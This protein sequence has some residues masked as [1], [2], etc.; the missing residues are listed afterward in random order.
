MAEKYLIIVGSIL[1]AVLG[2]IH[3]AYTFFSNKL[4]NSGANILYRSILSLGKLLSSA[5]EYFDFN[6]I[7][8]MVLFLNIYFK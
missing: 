6:S 8:V 7:I 2:S 5:E 3:L 1:L 4:F